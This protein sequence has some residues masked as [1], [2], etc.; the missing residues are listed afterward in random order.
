MLIKN[1]FKKRNQNIR[2]NILLFKFILASVVFDIALQK[3]K[4]MRKSGVN[5]IKLCFSV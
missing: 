4:H 2:L 5:A 3:S 1:E